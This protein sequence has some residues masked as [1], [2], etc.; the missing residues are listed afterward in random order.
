MKLQ[1]MKFLLENAVKEKSA[2]GAFTFWSLDSVQAIIEA[3]NEQT[4]PVIIMNGGIEAD[5]AGGLENMRCLANM[6]VKNSQ[7]PVALHLDHAEDYAFVKQA[8][9]V[10]YTSVMIDASKYE[11]AKNVEITQQVVEYAHKFGVTVE[12][13]LGRL[14]GTEG[15][16]EVKDEEAQQTSPQ[17]AK[18]FVELT[19]VDAL[20][21]AVGTAHGVYTFEPHINIRRIQEIKRAVDI[22]LVL[23]GGSGVPEDQVLDAIRNGIAKV[24]VC[25]DFLIAMGKTYIEVQQQEGFRYSAPALFS[26]SKKAGKEFILQ[27]IKRFSANAVK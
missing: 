17:E 14:K 11:F 8:I 27:N 26:P 21:V 9:D 18:R 22:Q 12:A 23:H 5:Y 19:G 7:V 24:N 16:V 6:A 2:V 4:A 10:G 13:E 3:A 25:T 20:A 15:E 1:P